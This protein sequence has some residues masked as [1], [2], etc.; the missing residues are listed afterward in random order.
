L[1]QPHNF[2]KLWLHPVQYKLS[3]ISQTS[4]DAIFV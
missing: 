1:W 4:Q 2:L 3:E